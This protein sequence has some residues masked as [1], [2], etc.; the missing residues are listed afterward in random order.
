MIKE[1][2]GMY[3]EVIDEFVEMKWKIDRYELDGCEYIHY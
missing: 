3:E 2:G 1:G